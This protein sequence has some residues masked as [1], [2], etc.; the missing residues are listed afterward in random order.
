M[1]RH[2][3][4][5]CEK[6]LEGSG[7]VKIKMQCWGFGPVQDKLNENRRTFTLCEMCYELQVNQFLRKEFVNQ[8]CS[9][10]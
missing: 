3:C 7:G 8:F 10:P 4:D 5:L 6:S 9:S 2:L 1:Y